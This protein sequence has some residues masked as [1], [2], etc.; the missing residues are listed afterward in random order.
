MDRRT[1]PYAPALGRELTAAYQ[2]RV[3]AWPSGTLIFTHFAK[4]I[5][6]SAVMS[7]IV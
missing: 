7:A 2:R 6:T 5:V 3:F 4:S 1:S